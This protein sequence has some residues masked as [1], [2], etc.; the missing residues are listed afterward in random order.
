[1]Q[2]SCLCLIRYGQYCTTSSNIPSPTST[3]CTGLLVTEWRYEATRWCDRDLG[4][5]KR[6][7]YMKIARTIFT[8]QIAS[9]SG[10]TNIN[11]YH[12]LE[13][14][15]TPWWGGGQ[16]R[17]TPPLGTTW[18]VG[19]QSAREMEQ[20]FRLRPFATPSQDVESGLLSWR[21]IGWRKSLR[22]SYSGLRFR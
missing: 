1:M 2:G 6:R 13:M 22:S 8:R 3:L 19:P 21:G 11:I 18:I 5:A 17:E 14:E 15:S 10:Y 9:S 16:L 7:W 12:G 20:P 4:Q